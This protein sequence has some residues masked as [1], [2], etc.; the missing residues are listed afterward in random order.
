[1]YHNKCIVIGDSNVG[2]SSLIT[3]YATNKFPK[4]IKQK[5]TPSWDYVKY[6]KYKNKS[7]FLEIWDTWDDDDY[8]NFRPLMYP[9]TD[10]FLICFS[11][12]DKKSFYNVKKKWRKELRSEY[13]KVPII[14]VGTKIDLRDENASTYDNNQQ[15]IKSS[16]GLKM[17]KKIGAVNYFEC[18]SLRNLGLKEIFDEV[19]KLILCRRSNEKKTK[20]H[21]CSLM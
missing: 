5:L 16:K 19:A 10:V 9:M 4:T 6:I 7:L 18:T 11:V 3:T 17:A 20:K 14:L 15:F 8:K 1:M 13:S 2:K 21:K 12:T